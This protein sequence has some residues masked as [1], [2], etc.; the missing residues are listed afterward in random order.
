MWK[1]SSQSKNL[2]VVVGVFIVSLFVPAKTSSTSTND[3]LHLITP[4]EPTV[5]VSKY[6]PMYFLNEKEQEWY[7]EV[8]FY[9][10]ESS[11]GEITCV[12]WESNCEGYWITM[13]NNGYQ[14]NHIDNEI[15][16]LCKVRAIVYFRV[17]AQIEFEISNELTVGNGEPLEV[18]HGSHNG[19]FYGQCN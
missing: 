2:L 16:D 15:G 14:R 6:G 4:K 18:Y 19:T 1:E 13:A 5:T 17:A 10:D 3:S 7:Q 9:F 11:Y 12:R 8:E